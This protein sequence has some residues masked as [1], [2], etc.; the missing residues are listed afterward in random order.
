MWVKKIKKYLC[1]VTVQLLGVLLCNTRGGGG[2]LNKQ[3]NKNNILIVTF[4]HKR[5]YYIFLRAKIR[6]VDM[7]ITKMLEM[8]I[9]N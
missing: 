2:I 6:D 4:Q 3:I 5:I 7:L 8:H 1:D 9:S